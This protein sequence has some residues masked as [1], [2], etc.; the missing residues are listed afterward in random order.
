M[1]RSTS[2]EYPLSE[3]RKCRK[4][5]VQQIPEI[6]KNATDARLPPFL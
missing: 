5:T 1:G 3:T 6:Q 2:K 4:F